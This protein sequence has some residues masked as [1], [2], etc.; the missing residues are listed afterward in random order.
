MRQAGHLIVAFHKHGGNRERRSFEPSEAVFDVVLMPIFPYGALERQASLRRIGGI[1]T[2]AQRGD[3]LGNRLLV[4]LDG[5]DL[6]AHPL[7]Y[8]LWAVRP[9]ASASHELDLLFDLPFK[10][11]AEQA[12]HAMLA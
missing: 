5:R 2:P 8:L 11:I 6:I 4:A 7:T 1:R 10:P 3:E 12:R 9:A